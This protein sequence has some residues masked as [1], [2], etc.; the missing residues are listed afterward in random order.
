MFGTPNRIGPLTSTASAESTER[1]FDYGGTVSKHTDPVP[2]VLSSPQGELKA[3]GTGVNTFFISNDSE[4]AALRSIGCINVSY[5][6]SLE[7]E[8]TPMPRSPISVLDY[9]A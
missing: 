4:N 3:V 1:N 6:S 8:K 5:G 2:T 7:E 9:E